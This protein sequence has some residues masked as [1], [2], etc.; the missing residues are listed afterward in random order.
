MSQRAKKT[1]PTRT[2][3]HTRDG[4]APGKYSHD[5]PR[6][7]GYAILL[8]ALRLLVVGSMMA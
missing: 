6:L 7:I 2:R 4:P 1:L 5:A 8:L 3:H